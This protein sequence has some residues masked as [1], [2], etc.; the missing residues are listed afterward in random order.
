MCKCKVGKSL[1]SGEAVSLS[2]SLFFGD[3]PRRTI[4]YRGGSLLPPIR[5][6]AIHVGYKTNI[7]NS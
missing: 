5:T 7:Q 4:G 3:S 1:K 2:M 6:F